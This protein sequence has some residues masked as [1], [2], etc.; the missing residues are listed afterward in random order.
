MSIHATTPRR[1]MGLTLCVTTLT[2][3]PILYKTPRLMPSPLKILIKFTSEYTIFCRILEDFKIRLLDS[4]CRLIKCVGYFY[5]WWK[6]IGV[7]DVDA[8]SNSGCLS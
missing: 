4:E 2:P 8:M 6:S 3:R 5:L 1:S 7:D